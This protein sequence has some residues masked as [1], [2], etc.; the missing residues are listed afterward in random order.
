MLEFDEYEEAY[1]AFS[2][3][4]D[5]G[6]APDYLACFQYVLR[7]ENLPDGSIVEYY[8][9]DD[10]SISHTEENGQT[11]DEYEY[12][13]DGTLRSIDFSNYPNRS[14]SIYYYNSDGVLKEEVARDYY[15]TRK[16]QEVVA[17]YAF[18]NGDKPSSKKLT[19]TIFSRSYPYKETS[20]SSSTASLSY[21]AQGRLTEERTVE[22]NG[23]VNVYTFEYDQYDNMTKRN[24]QKL[25]TSGELLNSNEETYAYEYDEDGLMQSK[26]TNG[27]Q[28]IT[29][30]Y[31]LF[32]V[33]DPES[34]LEH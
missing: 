12:N 3:I 22:E 14:L 29:Y 4:G 31:S 13:S 23:T 17:E 27:D 24:W 7:Q 26:T 25:G 1:A 19:T 34:P 5:W 20:V 32:F 15:R 30:S 8:Y 11:I 9:N 16:V 21:D 2:E 18:E 10:G 6:Q 28:K 33:D